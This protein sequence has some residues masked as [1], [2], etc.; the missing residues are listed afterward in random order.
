MDKQKGV[1]LNNV[2]PPTF[3]HPELKNMTLYRNRMYK[4]LID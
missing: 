4:D 3:V 1:W 2:S